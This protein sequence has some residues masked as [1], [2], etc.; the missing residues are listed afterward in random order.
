VLLWEV[1]ALAVFLCWNIKGICAVPVS[2]D[3]KH[4]QTSLNPYF[5]LS[6]NSQHNWCSFKSVFFS[7]NLAYSFSLVSSQPSLQD[8]CTCVCVCVC[9]CLSVVPNMTQ[10]ISVCVMYIKATLSKIFYL[11]I[12]FPKSF[13]WFFKS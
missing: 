1:F 9:V 6:Q 3:S 12:M 8:L 11:K 5:T 13:Q 7:H 4:L 10:C 2:T